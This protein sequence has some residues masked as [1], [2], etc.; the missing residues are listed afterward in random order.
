MIKSLK[1]GQDF[2]V[3]GCKKGE[4]KV[5][6]FNINKYDYKNMPSVNVLRNPNQQLL[7]Y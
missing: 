3:T 1:L 7:G 2:I 6:D 5:L 4:L